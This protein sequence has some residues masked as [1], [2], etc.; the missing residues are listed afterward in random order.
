[1]NIENPKQIEAAGEFNREI[2]ASLAN[3]KGVHAETAISAAARMAGTFVLR[4]TGLPLA[5]FEPGTTLLADVA[6]EYGQQVLA[7]VD[8]AL[9]SLG[10]AFDARNVN[11][12][13]SPEHDSHL[14]L[15]ETQ[16]LLD[17]GC[18]S[19]ADRFELTAAET[20]GSLAISTA[21]L[22]QQCAG[23]V[24]PHVA[25]AVVVYGMVEASKT[26]PFTGAEN[27]AAAG[28]SR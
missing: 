6:D 21:L 19:I 18:R 25:Y 4:S 1:M 26:V 10:V 24:D 14:D 27:G 3:G 5:D 11:Y 17:A 7:L 22:M 9:E 12:D 15:M 8:Q 23:V 16:T 2:I 20:A 28:G 13:L